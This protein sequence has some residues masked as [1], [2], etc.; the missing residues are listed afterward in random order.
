MH[1][2]LDL[3]AKGLRLLLMGLPL[4]LER[5]RMNQLSLLYIDL[6]LSKDLLPFQFKRLVHLI[7]ESLLLFVQ[8]FQLDLVP[9]LQCG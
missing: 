5:F 9:L 3:L 8:H 7:L 4:D 6:L 1:L 2:L